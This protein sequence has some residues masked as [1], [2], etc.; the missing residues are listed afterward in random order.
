MAVDNPR[1]VRALQAILEHNRLF[2]VL[3][4]DGDCYTVHGLVLN[5]RRL[6]GMR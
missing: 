6:H 3:A 2:P 5:P 1:Q 4:K